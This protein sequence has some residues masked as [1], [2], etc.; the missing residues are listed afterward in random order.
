MYCKKCGSDLKDN[1]EVCAKCGEKIEETSESK[2]KISKVYYAFKLAIV[3][4]ILLFIYGTYCFSSCAIDTNRLNKIDDT[5]W[6]EIQ[7]EIK[8]YNGDIN[9]ASVGLPS[10][11]VINIYDESFIPYKNKKSKILESNDS[12]DFAKW[13]S[14][15]YRRKYYVYPTLFGG[16]ALI[17]IGKVGKKHYE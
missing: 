8:N 2:N 1:D 17:I 15:Q 4:G 12:K 7:E 13:I 6:E 10:L 3:V 16:L 5:A 11:S 14:G 9:L